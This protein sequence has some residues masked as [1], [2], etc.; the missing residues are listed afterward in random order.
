MGCS[1]R[2]E[3]EKALTVELAAH[4]RDL[5]RLEVSIEEGLAVAAGVGSGAVVEEDLSLGAVPGQHGLL[6]VHQEGHEVLLVC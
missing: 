3:S 1:R 2:D 5:E 4:H 6:D